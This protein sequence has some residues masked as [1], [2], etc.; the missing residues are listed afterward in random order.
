MTLFPQSIAGSWSEERARGGT[1]RLCQ[2]KEGGFNSQCSRKSL[3]QTAV[4]SPSFG[5]TQS[6]AGMPQ[7]E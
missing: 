1:L 3:R 4:N 7:G 6:E 5:H 2:R